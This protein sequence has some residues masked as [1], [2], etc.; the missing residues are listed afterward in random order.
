VPVPDPQPLF[1]EVRAPVRPW[2]VTGVCLAGGLLLLGTWLHAA[3]GSQARAF[4]PG[5]WFY[6]VVTTGALAVALLGLWWS[7]RWAL[8]ALPAALL[9]DDGVVAAMGELRWGVV[10]AQLGVVGTVLL[11]TVGRA[12]R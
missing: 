8:L 3:R 9:L 6:L 5:Y 7:K 4:G 10:V 11:A 2:P 1:R 12:R